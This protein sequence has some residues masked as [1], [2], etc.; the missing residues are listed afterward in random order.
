MVVGKCGISKS[1]TQKNIIFFEKIGIAAYAIKP[2]TMSE[3]ARF[4]RTV[5]DKQ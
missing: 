5:L 2:V 3:I 1:R 4:I